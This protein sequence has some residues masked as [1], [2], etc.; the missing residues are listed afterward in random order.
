MN[1]PIKF[2]LGGAVIGIS[3]ILIEYFS[4][5]GS[6][7]LR[8]ALWPSQMLWMDYD[9]RAPMWDA[10]LWLIAF[11]TNSLLFGTPAFLFGMLIHFFGLRWQER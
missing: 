2:R 10:S 8:L 6:P 11:L 3:V 5:F 7:S 4:H 9:P 1:L